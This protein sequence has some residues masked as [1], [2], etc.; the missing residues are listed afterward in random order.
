MK[1]MDGRECDSGAIAME[2]SLYAP[3]LE[4]RLLDYLAGIMDTLDGSLGP[5]FTY[6]PIAYQDD[7]QICAGRSQFVESAEAF[8]TVRINFLLGD[9]PE[10]AAALIAFLSFS[11]AL[12]YGRAAKKL[13]PCE[14]WRDLLQKLTGQDTAL[15]P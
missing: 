9:G 4:R 10:L 13:K 12:P 5:N 6:L 3:R 15:C 7:C 8:Y 1:A 14:S 2:L 11:L